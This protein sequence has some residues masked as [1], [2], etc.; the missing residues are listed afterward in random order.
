[1]IPVPLHW[2]TEPF[3]VCSLL[4]LA[5]IYSICI[6]PMRLRLAQGER[7]SASEACLFYGGIVLSYLVVASP[8][9]QV[10][11]DFLFSVHMVQ[12][13]RENRGPSTT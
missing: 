4:G 8:L 6:G 13:Q 7:F 10:G 2:H 9:D 11:E 1:M 5:W 3:L 12:A